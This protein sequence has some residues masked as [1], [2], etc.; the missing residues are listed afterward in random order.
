MFDLSKHEIPQASALFKKNLQLYRENWLFLFFSKGNID[1]L[2]FYV[3]VTKASTFVTWLLVKMIC[4]QFCQKPRFYSSSLNS[5]FPAISIFMG[6]S[7]TRQFSHF[8]TIHYPTHLKNFKP[9]RL[10]RICTFHVLSCTLHQKKTF[11]IMILGKR[12][13]EKNGKSF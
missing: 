5:I 6:N 4:F 8:R 13:H 2:F 3:L 11:F 9:P 7:E 12:M 10:N 1:S